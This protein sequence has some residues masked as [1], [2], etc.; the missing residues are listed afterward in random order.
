M[1]TKLLHAYI[2]ELVLED[3]SSLEKWARHSPHAIERALSD[4][5]LVPVPRGDTVKD[6]PDSYVGSG[7]YAD[8]YEV[9]YKGKRAVAKLALK[10]DADVYHELMHDRAGLPPRIA[11]HLPVIYDVIEFDPAAGR[12]AI[13]T[14][15]LVP[16]TPDVESA[17]FGAHKGH[18]NR[19]GMRSNANLLINDP[20]RLQT[21]VRSAIK[22]A[23]TIPHMSYLETSELESVLLDPKNFSSL[24]TMIDNS[25]SDLNKSLKPKTSFIWGLRF[26]K[27]KCVSF[28]KPVLNLLEKGLVYSEHDEI[29][30]LTS[31]ANEI[32]DELLG[33][34]FPISV[35][36]RARHDLGTSTKGSKVQSLLDALDYI[37]HELNWDWNDLRA[38]N[39]MMR[40]KTGEL[41]VSDVG[42]WMK[43]KT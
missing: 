16:M 32:Y 4:I 37:T 9:L 34:R 25:I 38:E 23:R 30:I 42:C 17:Y 26:V 10:A 3:S 33:D 36:D 20:E 39:I 35:Y 28:L 12:W 5:G 6:R 24:K 43:T 1:L 14:E 29:I 31:I 11:R 40:P 2:R 7:A 13:V 21:V 15:Y 19:T 18:H 22:S 8:V 41:V 27:E